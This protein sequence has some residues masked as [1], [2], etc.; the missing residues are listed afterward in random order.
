[1]ALGS[2]YKDIFL[3]FVFYFAMIVIFAIIGSQIITTDPSV[4]LDPY[5]NNYSNLGRMI[6]IVYVLGTYDAYPDNQLPAI[7]SNIYYYGFFILFIF[8]NMFIFSS[9]PG[10]IVFDTFR[11][12]RGRLQ[13][14]DEIRMQNSLIVAFI[15]IGEE[16]YQMEVNRLIKFLLYF[17]EN[18]VRFIDVVTNICLKLNPNDHTSVDVNEFMQLGR[19]LQENSNLRPPPLSDWEWWVS[20]RRYVQREWSIKQKMQSTCYRLMAAL[21]VLLGFVNAVLFLSSNGEGFRVV[22]LIFTNLF[23]L[24]LTLELV[25]V[26]PEN[27]FSETLSGVDFFMTVLGFFIQFFSGLARH[28]AL[29][30]ILRVYRTGYLFQVLAQNRCWKFNI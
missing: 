28:G 30:R 12:T 17:Y 15:T 22:D 16:N 27:Y 2:A 24:E 4:P 21:L 26:G 10:S 8:L 3:C 9:I 11:E 19:I 6:F 29:L 1:M 14:L 5:V 23:V 18:R 7:E 25:A 13:L 20:F